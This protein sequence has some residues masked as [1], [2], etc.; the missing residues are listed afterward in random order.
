MRKVGG[1]MVELRARTRAGYRRKNTVIVT[2]M[3][4]LSVFSLAMMVYN[5][6]KKEWLFCVAWFIALILAATYVLIRINSVFA[7]YIATDRENLY[8]KNWSNDFLPYDYDSKLKIFSEFIP[9]KTKLVEIPLDEIHTVVIGTKNFVKR[10]TD[11]SMP[12]HKSLKKIEKTK[13]FYRKKTLS[14]MDIFYVETYAR[15]CYY[16]PIVNFDTKDV[17]KI[18][19]IMAR[20]NIDLELKVGSRDYRSLL[21][22]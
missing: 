3:T 1:Q 10:N 18:V 7:T 15:E 19:Q 13:D 8:M 6:I 9:A 11:A 21:K 4:L 20:K 17:T 2:A 5:L 22:G 14:S 16:M 12:F